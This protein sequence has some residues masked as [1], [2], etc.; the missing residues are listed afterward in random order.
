[1]LLLPLPAAAEDE[2]Y[3]L[4][5]LQ[6]SGAIA[7]GSLSGAIAGGNFDTLADGSLA[8]YLKK[9]CAARIKSKLAGVRAYSTLFRYEGGGA[10]S[11]GGASG[12]MFCLEYSTARRY[13]RDSRFWNIDSQKFLVD[14]K[15]R[16][17]AAIA[18]ADI[19]EYGV[20]PLG[21]DSGLSAALDAS[22]SALD[23][24]HE[25][26]YD[27]NAGDLGRA[28]GIVCRDKTL[29]ALD[30]KVAA[31][32]AGLVKKHDSLAAV[33]R[34]WDMRRDATLFPAGLEILYRSMLAYLGCVGEK[35]G[36]DGCKL[37]EF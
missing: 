22:M 1:M 16:I 30:V 4:A 20:F 9:E 5:V 36:V 14:F 27:C 23:K 37:E 8:K 26:S 34:G 24:P 10:Y 6:S 12:R 18:R 11:D 3:A 19:S 28:A 2:A 7:E 29:A 35:G 21:D 32:Y 17:P 15:D 33:K 13:L 25:T 31:L